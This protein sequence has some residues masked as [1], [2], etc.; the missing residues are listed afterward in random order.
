MLGKNLVCEN[1]EDE[2]AL[3]TEYLFS[4]YPL[5]LPGMNAF[6][7]PVSSNTVVFCGGVPKAILAWGVLRFVLA[8][9]F[10]EMYLTV[11]PLATSK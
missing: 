11:S 10:C 8:W 4:G 9:K 6:Q 1:V 7:D 2:L 3:Y 5:I